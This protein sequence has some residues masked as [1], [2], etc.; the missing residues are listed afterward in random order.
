MYY[1]STTTT[2][3]YNVIENNLSYNGVGADAK[4]FLAQGQYSP[5]DGACAYGIIY[6]YNT[7]HDLQG[8]NL[9]GYGYNYVKIYNNTYV[10]IF[11]GSG[12][13]DNFQTDTYAMTYG[14]DLNDIWYFPNAVT[15]VLYPIA[16]DSGSTT[17]GNWG[18]G[19][20]YCNAS[21]SS[22]CTLYRLAGG[23]TWTSYPGN[24]LGYANQSP[25]TNNPNFVNVSAN[26]FNLQAGSPAI[27]A[28][29]Y[30]TT[31]NG[32]GTGS[33]SLVVNDAYYFQDSY[34]LSNAYSTV[35]PDCIAVA[36]VSNHVCVT[37]VNYST[38]TLTL[39]SPISW[40]NGSHIWLYSKSDGVQVLTGSAPDM[41]AYPYGVG[42]TP[43]A[44]PTGL[45]AVVN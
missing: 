13:D 25:N 42:A 20:A 2:T 39:A 1:S 16:V 43:P 19:L 30:L 31:A 15:S 29:T 44:A 9:S 26:N 27:A 32:S 12:G 10:N 7:L 28:G 35:H 37:A 18:Y 8:S 17:G 3:D 5:C 24:I 40:S 22:N 34:G 45:A 21:G 23:G 38:N 14:A 33:T 6:R 36:T 4:G 11:G 41:G